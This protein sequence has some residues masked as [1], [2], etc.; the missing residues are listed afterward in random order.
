M[1]DIVSE[2]I[3]GLLLVLFAEFNSDEIH[4]E[5]HTRLFNCDLLK[6][7]LADPVH[8]EGRGV[9]DFDEKL[10]LRQR[11]VHI[12]YFTVTFH[13]H[14]YKHKLFRVEELVYTLYLYSSLPVERD[15]RRK[16]LD[17]G[18]LFD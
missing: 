7:S 5:L 14:V 12:A 18:L 10:V 11:I 8:L 4:E 16:Y 15:E 17:G 9:L 1:L 13:W 6:E 3:P 2:L